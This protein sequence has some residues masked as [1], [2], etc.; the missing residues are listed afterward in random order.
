MSTS[1]VQV[2]LASE[3]T[4]LD[5]HEQFEATEAAL[6]VWFSNAIQLRFLLSWTGGD[7]WNNQVD[8]EYDDVEAMVPRPIVDVFDGL[9]ND[10]KERAK[11]S[12]VRC[13]RYNHLTSR[14]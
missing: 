1:S 11:H 4:G 9:R 3:N 2:A 12:A 10:A 13:S 6:T 14:L 8:L 7:L 5:D